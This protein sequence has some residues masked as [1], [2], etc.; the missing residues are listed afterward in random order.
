M[1]IVQKV[2]KN[3]PLLSRSSQSNEDG[4]AI[5]RAEKKNLY[6]PRQPPGIA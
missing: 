1:E 3:M 2:E 5:F 4:L 6:Q